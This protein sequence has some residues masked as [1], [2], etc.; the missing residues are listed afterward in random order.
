MKSRLLRHG[1]T[2]CELA[3]TVKLALAIGGCENLQLELPYGIRCV[4]S[5]RYWRRGRLWIKCGRSLAARAENQDSH[6]EKQPHI[7]L[8]SGP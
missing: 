1:L 6:Q 8:R 4:A 7:T 5:S 3:Q 2:P